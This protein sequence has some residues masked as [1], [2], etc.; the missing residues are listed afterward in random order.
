MTAWGVGAIPFNVQAKLECNEDF[1][2]MIQV[3]QVRY[4]KAF[5]GVWMECDWKFASNKTIRHK[6][7]SLFTQYHDS[8]MI[9]G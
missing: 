3:T 8:K 9:H 5:R 2:L 6:E 7:I 4:A 1:A